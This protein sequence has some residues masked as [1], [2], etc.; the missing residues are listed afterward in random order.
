MKPLT[1]YQA[2]QLLHIHF[3]GDFAY[4][5]AAGTRVPS[6]QWRRMIDV[7]AGGG[8]VIIDRGVRLTAKGRDYLDCQHTTTAR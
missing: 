1:D 4:R 6:A 7:L 2:A 8:Y 3:H 5:T